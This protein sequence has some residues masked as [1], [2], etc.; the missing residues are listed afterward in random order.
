MIRWHVIRKLKE[1]MNQA[2]WIER[3]TAAAMSESHRT[4]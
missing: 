1:M 4:Q 3:E 2:M